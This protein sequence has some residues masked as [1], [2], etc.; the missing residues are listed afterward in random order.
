[1][2]AAGELGDVVHNFTG[3]SSFQLFF[4]SGITIPLD[5]YVTDEK[6]DLNQYYKFCIDLLKVDGKLGALPFKGHPSRVGIFHNIDLLQKAGAKIPTND[7]TYDELIESAKK[8]HKASGDTVETFGWSNPGRDMEYYIIMSRFGGKGDLFSPDGKKSRLNEAEVQAGWTWT[9]DMFNVH[10]VGMNPLATNPDP[11]QAFLNGKLALFR[12]N[13]GTKAAFQK[14]DA[15]K[16]GMSVAP[17]GPGGQRGSLAQADAVGVTKFSKL[18]DVA[19]D[20]V[21]TMT[22]KDSGIVLGKQTGNK[23]ATPGGR[24]DVYESPDL[25][26]LPYPEGVQQNTA[27]AMKEAE[28]AILPGNFRGP[29]AQRAI[30][31]LYEAL[32]LGKEQPNKAFYDK[33]HLAVQ[34]VLDKGRP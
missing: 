32:V 24:P 7:S 26:G 27:I 34:D 4:A 16:W 30:D 6:F 9:S 23:S 31:P 28:P 33:M 10:K 25:T 3:D 19:W 12:A 8:T 29:E 15:F 21:K 13:V 17:K 1:M 22:S 2:V 20:Y 5:Q 14:I 18:P 11:S